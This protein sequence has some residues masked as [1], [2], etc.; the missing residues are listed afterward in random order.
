MVNGS[1]LI[2]QVLDLFA[3]RS[4]GL[5]DAMVSRLDLFA[6]RPAGLVDT[7]VNGSYLIT[8][9]LDLFT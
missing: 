6:Q 8:Q 7:M 5:V 2:T 1:Y 3:Q 4:V 9:V